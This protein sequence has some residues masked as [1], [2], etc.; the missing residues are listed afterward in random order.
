MYSGGQAWTGAHDVWLR[1][2]RLESAATRLAFESDYDAVLTVKARRDRLDAAIAVMAADSEFTSVVHRLGCL[3]GVSTLTGFALAV[4]IGDWHRFTGNT[5]GS[6]VGIGAQR[7]LLGRSRVRGRSP[8]PATATPVGCWSRPP[9]T[10]VPATSRARRCGTDG[11]SP[12]RLLEPAAMRA[13]GGCITVG[14][15]SPNGANETP[16]PTSRSPASWPAGAGRW[17]S[18]TTDLSSGFVARGGWWQREERPA[19][20][21]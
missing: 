21:L 5:I 12:R 6:F 18:W 3:R 2:Q 20:Q 17:P 16:S 15:S 9:G 8:R 10:T 7:A 19:T 1:R 14:W 4:E 11:S 13:T